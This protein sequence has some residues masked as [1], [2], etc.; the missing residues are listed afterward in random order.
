MVDLA[1]QK[2]WGNQGF[3]LISVSMALSGKARNC[4]FM[5]HFFKFFIEFSEILLSPQSWGGWRKV[6]HYLVFSWLWTIGWIFSTKK[7]LG[8]FSYLFSTLTSMEIW[9]FHFLTWKSH[10]WA[11]M[12]IKYIKHKIIMWHSGTLDQKGIRHVLIICLRG[13]IHPQKSWK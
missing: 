4:P 6:F 10:E 7:E 3:I 9:K 1:G 11:Q 13:S 2:L 12:S 8:R 5:I